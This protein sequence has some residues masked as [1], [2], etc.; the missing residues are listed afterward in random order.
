MPPTEVMGWLASL[1]ADSHGGSQSPDSQAQ[2]FL[3]SAGKE[4]A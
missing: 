2:G 4:S 3:N 1:I